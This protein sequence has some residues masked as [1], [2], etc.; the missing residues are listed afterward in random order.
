MMLLELLDNHNF[1]YIWER[2][3]DRK[4]QEAFNLLK[5]ENLE[6]LK[7]VLSELVATEKQKRSK[8]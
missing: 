7:P 5:K 8:P 3:S 1:L 4:L 2:S 6:A